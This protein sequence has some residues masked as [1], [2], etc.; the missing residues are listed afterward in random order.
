MTQSNRYKK[1]IIE[2]FCKASKNR[3]LFSALLDDIL[4]PKELLDLATR[5]QI[6]K[7]LFSGMAQRKISKDLGVSISKITRGS[8]VLRDKNC[9]LAKILRDWRS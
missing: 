6:T 2:L 1:E 4:T 9:G 8:R 7:R 5:W 3:R